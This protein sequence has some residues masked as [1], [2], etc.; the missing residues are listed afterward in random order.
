[1]KLF[2]A[3]KEVNELDITLS[4]PNG[5]S[6]FVHITNINEKITELLRGNMEQDDAERNEE[7][8]CVYVGFLC[9][10]V[11]SKCKIMQKFPYIYT[12]TL[13][14]V[15]NSKNMHKI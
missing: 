9:I 6:G 8:V 15:E 1:M 14:I 12:C 3:V 11:T 5:L 10:L 2:G 13:Y 7:E 4:L